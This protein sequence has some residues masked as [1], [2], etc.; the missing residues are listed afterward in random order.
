MNRP[1]FVILKYEE[2]TP[3]MAMC[4]NC[5]LKF[6]TPRTRANTPAEA[7]RYLWDR[8]INHECQVIEIR[9]F[10]GKSAKKRL[11]S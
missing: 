4:W 5:K 2:K 7:E 9:P 10:Q 11:I 1:P 3:S 8:F 6:F